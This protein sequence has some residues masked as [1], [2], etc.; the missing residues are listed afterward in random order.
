MFGQ[1]SRAALRR[2]ARN[3]IPFITSVLLLAAPVT[4]RAEATRAPL[5]ATVESLLAAV[6]ALSPDLRAAA[7][8]AA[9]AAAQADAAGRLDDPTFQYMSDEGD[10][11]GGPR[12]NKLD[13]TLT[14][15]VPLWGKLGLRHAA[16]MAA[17]DAAREQEGVTVALLD[18]RIKV[19]FARYYAVTQ[20]LAVNRR[21]AALAGDIAKA[22]AVRYGQGLG[23]QSEVILARAEGIQAATEA[24]KLTG[25]RD[26][27]V[28]QINGLLARPADATLAAPLGP[29]PLPEVMPAISVLMDR[30]RADNPTLRIARAELRGAEADRQLAHKAWYPDPI[31]SIGVIQRDFGPTGYT[32]GVA[33]SVPLQWTA[34]RAGEQAAAARRDAARQKLLS[35]EAEIGGALGQALASFE[36]ARRTDT[37]LRTELAPQY[38]RAYRSLLA[39]YG[40]D[41]A[42]LGAVLEIEHRLHQTELD[43]LQADTDAH[44]A[45]AAI[46]RLIGGSL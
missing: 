37:L 34:K 23:E 7:L 17:S 46:E 5:G 45:L 25:Q 15:T 36:A 14:Q 43:Q 27:V 9:A 16:A 44:T 28:A 30:A 40:Q 39:R 42:D 13:F 2:C 20:A 31:F 21:I 33:F 32:G 8:D 26:A 22:A 35:G 29:W 3:A 4:A 6:R 11:T 19:A 41:R 12:M 1:H 38:R 24:A 18:E 10:R